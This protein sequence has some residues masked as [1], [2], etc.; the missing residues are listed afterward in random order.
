MNSLYEA[1]EPLITTLKDLD[2]IEN[3]FWGVEGGYKVDLTTIVMIGVPKK[4]SESVDKVDL[5]PPAKGKEF[6]K[7]EWLFRT[8]QNQKSCYLQMYFIYH[9]IQHLEIP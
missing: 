9:Y 3:K 8:R 7:S 4:F 1:G 2:V 6:T 5:A